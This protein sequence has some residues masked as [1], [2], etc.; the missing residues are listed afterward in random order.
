MYNSVDWNVYYETKR[1]KMFK[2]RKKQMRKIILSQEG[3]S[4]CKTLAS[5]VPDAEVETDTATIMNLARALNIREL[6][7]V[8]LTGTLSEL[9]EVLK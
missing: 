5:Q 3:C 1:L 9:A 7:I 6:P 2:E 4:K 8:V